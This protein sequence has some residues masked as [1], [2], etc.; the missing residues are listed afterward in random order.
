MSV[1]S[2]LEGNNAE[3]QQRATGCEHTEWDGISMENLHFFL[4]RIQHN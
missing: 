1:Y 3:V 2:G 4:F